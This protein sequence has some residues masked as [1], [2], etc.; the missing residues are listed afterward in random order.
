MA[1]SATLLASR[2][3]KDA[4]TCEVLAP[5]QFRPNDEQSLVAACRAGDPAG[6][7]ELYDRHC[8]QVYR[9]MHRM[10][11][12]EHADDLTQQVFLRVIES[13]AKFHGRSTLSTWLYRL[14]TN[15][16]LQFLRR[17]ARRTAQPLIADPPDHRTPSDLRLDARELLERALA[18]LEPDLRATFLLREVE[19][20]SYYD[21]AVVLDIAEGTVAS[22][23]NRARQLLR[24]S[25]SLCDN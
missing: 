6:Q 21:I 13:I 15:E 25:I 24:A 14:A 9:L 7:R 5:Q 11:G 19:Q 16:A 17:R 1:T 22:R 23:L 3:P 18:N 10:V 8:Q 2:V 4:P 20:L 12:H